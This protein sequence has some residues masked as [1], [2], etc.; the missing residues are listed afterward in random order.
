MKYTKQ[1][2]S[3][4]LCS[5]AAGALSGAVTTLYKFL[6]AG[7]VS[8]S[9]LLY[10]K[11]VFLPILAVAMVLAALMLPKVYRKAPELK[12]GGIPTAIAAI[13]GLRPLPW[14]RNTAGPFFLSLLSFVL[15]IP[16][17]TE[18]PSVQFSAAIGGGISRLLPRSDEKYCLTAGASAGFA[19]ATGAP[20]A[21]LLFAVE[22]AH[23]SV[24]PLI[25]LSAGAA[26]FCANTASRLLS[27]MLGVSTALFA[28][29]KLPVLS[30]KELWLPLAMGLITGLFATLFLKGHL[31]LRKLFGRIS[32]R[33]PHWV[34]L[35]MIFSATLLCGFF[36]P[37]FISTGHHLVQ[38]LLHEAPALSFLL[39]V[40]LIRSVLTLSAN[41]AGLTGGTFLPQ[42]AIGAALSA[43]IASLL[44]QWGV[45]EAYAPLLVTFGLCGCV[46][47]MMKMPITALAFSVEA[48]GLSDNLLSLL[49]VVGL[50]YLLPKLFRQV[51]IC[52]YVLEHSA[53]KEQKTHP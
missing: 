2:L 12:G 1:I 33:I 44:L 13:R 27:P 37:N 38:E 31:L 46:A 18:G 29:P 11:A 17:G 36:S 7:A 35:L 49:L 14:L 26:V 10:S 42:L 48:L 28:L 24:S 8:L 39:L 43:A 15:G 50:S 6:T 9:G 20:L 3:V 19:V 21:G 30:L 51:S 45:P 22:E 25:L 4:V 5:A 40:V 53:Y 41:A 23:R 52:D 16:L 47:G 34:T 32:G